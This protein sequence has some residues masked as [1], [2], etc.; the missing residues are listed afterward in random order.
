LQEENLQLKDE[1]KKAKI[2]KGGA[3]CN[4]AMAAPTNFAPG[5]PKIKTEPGEIKITTT[6]RPSPP[7]FPHSYPENVV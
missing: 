6:V 5:P 4:P 7:S 3:V 1:V 2:S